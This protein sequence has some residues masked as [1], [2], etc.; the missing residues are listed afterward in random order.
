MKQLFVVAL[1]IFSPL[2]HGEILSCEQKQTMCETKCKATSIV[3]EQDGNTCKAQCLGERTA[4]ELE[5]SKESAGKMAEQ[6][7]EASKSFMDTVKAFWQGL[8]SDL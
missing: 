3:S 7:K 2:L 6:A 8:T 4:C 5:H 1:F